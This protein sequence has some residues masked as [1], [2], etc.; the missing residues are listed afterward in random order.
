MSRIKVGD[1]VAFRRD[2]VRKCGHSNGVGV[3]AVR[4]V[5]TE[6][7]GDWL[8]MTEAGGRNKVMPV[9]SMCKVAHNGVILELV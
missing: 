7:S 2:V 5:V 3:G 4:G 9:T 1:T 6:I 8:F